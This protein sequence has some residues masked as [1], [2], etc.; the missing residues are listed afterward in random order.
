MD[1]TK[2]YTITLDDD[3]MVHKMIHKITNMNSLPF[4]SAS[5][6]I[7][8]ASHYRPVAAF[9]DIYLENE[10]GLHAIPRL[11]EAWQQTPII[12]ITGD[13]SKDVIGQALAAGAHDFIRKPL[14]PVEVAS[15]MQARVQEQE[16]RHRAHTLQIGPLMFDRVR[17][18][19]SLDNKNVYLPPKDAE[20]LSALCDARGAPVSKKILK[21]KIWGDITVSDNALDRRLSDLRKTFSDLTGDV[22]IKS[23]Y[24]KGAKLVIH[25]A[26]SL[27]TTTQHKEVA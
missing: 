11:R 4:T 8:K 1:L 16:E 22:S 13:D 24:G 21:R 15:R 25:G 12:V 2:S 27:I 7:E 23:I 10:D 17:Q 14:D 19:L 18:V 26:D 5:K 6:L 3:P 20:L 9:V